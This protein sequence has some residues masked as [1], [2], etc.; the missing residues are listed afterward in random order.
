MAD[1]HF[2]K[3]IVELQSEIVKVSRHN[4]ALEQKCKDLQSELVRHHSQVKRRKK[5]SATRRSNSPSDVS[6]S[7]RIWLA[8]FWF[9]S[10]KMILARIW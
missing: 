5:P 9:R 10:L 7:G 1:I 6:H 3:K 8:A 4:S 2:Y